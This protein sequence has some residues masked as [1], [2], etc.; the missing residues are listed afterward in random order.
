MEDSE[1]ALKPGF[2]TPSPFMVWEQ[3]HPARSPPKD[4][5]IKVPMVNLSTFVPQ[6]I[7]RQPW[8]LVLV[9]SSAK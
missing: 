1:L 9:L 7:L 8:L 3:F 6:Q 2:S 4:I 5:A